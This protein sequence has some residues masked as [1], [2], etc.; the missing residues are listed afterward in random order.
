LE[1]ISEALDEKDKT[2]S[3][4]EYTIDILEKQNNDLDY[5]L[6]SGRNK[7]E[8]ERIQRLKELENKLNQPLT[9]QE[10]LFNLLK[11]LESEELTFCFEDEDNK[12][13]LEDKR[14]EGNESKI[15][16]FSVKIEDNNIAVFYDDGKA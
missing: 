5:L 6:N 7:F 11:K 9:N 13:Y 3:Q 2:I 15:Y 14:T 10:L 4:L 1:T 16:L 12:L 8:Q